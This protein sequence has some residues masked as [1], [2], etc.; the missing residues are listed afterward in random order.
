MSKKNTLV[1]TTD[2]G[3][4]QYLMQAF[5]SETWQ[6]PRCGHGDDTASMDSARFLREYLAAAPAPAPSAAPGVAV[7]SEWISELCGPEVD[8]LSYGQG[9][10]RGFNQCRSAVLEMD[11][12]RSQAGAAAA[13]DVLAERRRQREQEGWMLDHDDA[14]EGGE[15]AEAAMCYADPAAHC[16]LGIP[17][18]WPWVAEWWK[19]RERRRNLVRA[20]ALIIAEIERLDRADVAA[21]LAGEEPK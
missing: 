3:M 1:A 9:F 15:L 18:Q 21:K 6:C 11:A 10:R 17:H 8:E 2:R 12:V 13:H 16:Q 4:L 5:D 14:H 19:P 7:P 20:G